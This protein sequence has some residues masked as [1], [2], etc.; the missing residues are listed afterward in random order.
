MFWATS[1]SAKAGA[2]DVVSSKGKSDQ[3]L[4]IAAPVVAEASTALEE[5]AGGFRLAPGEVHPWHLPAMPSQ[6][7][8][9]ASPTYPVLVSPNPMTTTQVR[10]TL[11]YRRYSGP[12]ADHRH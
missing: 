4:Q 8:L 7:K 3:E 2:P 9:R 5:C 12:T 1:P 10:F 11:S 6:E